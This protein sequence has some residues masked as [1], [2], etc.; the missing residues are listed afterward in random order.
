MT[1]VMGYTALLGIDDTSLLA[2]GD[3]PSLAMG[4][5]SSLA[6]YALSGLGDV[7]A[8]IF[9]SIEYQSNN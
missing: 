6:Y 5:T 8:L 4:Y 2:M 9:N 1:L 3:T 7:L